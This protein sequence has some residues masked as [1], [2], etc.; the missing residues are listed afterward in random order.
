MRLGRYVRFSAASIADGSRSGS[1]AHRAEGA[2]PLGGAQEVGGLDA[3]DSPGATGRATPDDPDWTSGRE[4]PRIGPMASHG[5]TRGGRRPPSRRPPGTGS[6]LVR[7]DRAG[8][9]TWYGKWRVGERQVMRRLGPR[10]EP[11]ASVGLTRTQAEAELRRLIAEENGSLGA[12]R[13]DLEQLAPRFLAHKETIGPAP[14]DAE[15]LRGHAARPP[16]PVL[17]RPL[18]RPDHAG[19]GRGVH[20]RR[21]CA[22]ASRARRSTTT[23]ACSRRCSATRSSA[24]TPASTR[25]TPPTGRGSS[26]P[27]PTSAT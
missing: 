17:R 11:G 26:G 27:T 13:L 9:E 14:H 19:R 3:G 6:L 16:R 21:S 7:R 4:G 23:S 24:A 22:T 25:S 18:A 15:R 5:D 8:R 1:E 2:D 20:P 10:R 12:E